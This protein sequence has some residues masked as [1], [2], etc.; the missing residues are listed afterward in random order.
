MGLESAIDEA[1]QGNLKMGGRGFDEITSVTHKTERGRYALFVDSSHGSNQ[2]V[3]FNALENTLSCMSGSGYTF[4]TI[5]LSE[6]ATQKIKCA[7][8]SEFVVEKKDLSW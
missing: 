7:I 6:N 4:L 3:S 8:E 5:E 2:V 1:V